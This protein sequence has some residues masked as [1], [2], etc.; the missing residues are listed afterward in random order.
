MRRESSNKRS[1]VA[2]VNIN[3]LIPRSLIAIGFACG[4]VG[5]AAAQE[6][7][8][9]P[10]VVELFASQACSSCVAAADY[11]R[12][13]SERKD[14]VALAWHVDYWNHLNTK[15]GRW[16]DPYS[17]AANTARQRLYNIN[18]R[19]RSSVYTP[20]MIVGGVAEC[21]GS[22]R[23]E[24]AALIEKTQLEL[25]VVTIAAERGG[26]AIAFD[27]GASVKGGNAF[28]ITFK[29]QALTKIKGGEN[30]GVSFKDTNVVTNV[31]RLGVVRSMGGG[32]TVAPPK[33][34]EGCALLVQ[35]PRQ[36]RI[37]AARYCPSG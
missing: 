23:D 15:K 2:R 8:P 5:T 9:A 33:A 29:P 34:G 1:R 16:V 27:I 17:S 14:I 20:Q 22:S 3:A 26:N 30:A 24:A 37:I 19:K 21:V 18:L 4:F 6:T 32:V 35:E 36:G 7:D 11:F 25:P 10:V 28:L 12:E 13:L 31:A